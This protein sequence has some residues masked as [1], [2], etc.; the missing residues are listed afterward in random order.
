MH[1]RSGSWLAAPAALE[2]ELLSCAAAASLNSRIIWVPVFQSFLF[3]VLTVRSGTVT[4]SQDGSAED[5]NPN[6]LQPH[7]GATSD[8]K[9]PCWS[10]K[11]SC[12]I[13][14]R[15]IDNL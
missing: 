1:R 4:V 14:H 13:S 3:P 11:R 5:A 9:R 8:H 6:P 12:Q 15:R 2:S 7:V 10:H